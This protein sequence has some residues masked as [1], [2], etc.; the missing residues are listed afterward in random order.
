MSPAT[1][2]CPSPLAKSTI[3][4][5]D[6]TLDTARL[7]ILPLAP[8]RWSLELLRP[9]VV[10]LQETE[11]AQPKRVNVDDLMACIAVAPCRLLLAEQALLSLLEV[12]A[13]VCPECRL[14]AQNVYGLYWAGF[15]S[16]DV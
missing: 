16:G 8:P 1:L 11:D 9:N 10:H 13:E 4:L 14:V 6:S 5:G 15:Q 3:M 7:R 2:L 12:K